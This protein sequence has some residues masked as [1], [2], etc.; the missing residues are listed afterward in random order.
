M[1]PSPC[2]RLFNRR[3]EPHLDQM[4]HGAVDDPTGHRLQKL[5]VRKSIEIPGQ[6]CINDFDMSGVDQLMDVSYRV[7]CAAVTP[8][9][10]LFRL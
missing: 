7:Q 5:G 1:L 4:E 9:G 8:V 6:I 2:V 10:I 3:C